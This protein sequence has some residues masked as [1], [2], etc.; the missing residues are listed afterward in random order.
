MCLLKQNFDKFHSKRC[1]V[2][3]NQIL[4][5][6][7]KHIESL[8]AALYIFFKSLVE[9]FTSLTFNLLVIIWVLILFFPYP[10]IKT[11]L[12]TQASSIRIIL[13]YK[14]FSQN[15]CS[16]ETIYII[17]VPFLWQVWLN[18]QTRICPSKRLH[19]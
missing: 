3:H 10:S 17:L 15:K 16:I 6:S 14:K 2:R 11:L 13:I 19:L 4:M 8:R 7:F 1:K 5:S 18:I 9:M 12:E